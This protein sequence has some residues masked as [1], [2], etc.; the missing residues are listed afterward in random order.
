MAK[1]FK[2]LFG[3]AQSFDN[4]AWTEFVPKVPLINELFKLT[5]KQG[6]FILIWWSAW[7]LVTT[8]TYKILNALLISS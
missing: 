1:S 6:P 7:I 3:L 8:V 5:T 2:Y 4:F